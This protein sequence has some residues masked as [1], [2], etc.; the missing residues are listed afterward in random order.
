M[1]T[2]IPLWD[3]PSSQLDFVGVLDNANLKFVGSDAETTH[4]GARSFQ[5]GTAGNIWELLPCQGTVLFTNFFRASKSGSRTCDREKKTMKP[6]QGQIDVEL[7]PALENGMNLR[8]WQLLCNYAGHVASGYW[9]Q[10][11]NT[12]ASIQQKSHIN[13][14]LTLVLRGCK[15]NVAVL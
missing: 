5:R 13:G 4:L 14:T 7:W 11:S 6:S 12:V 8:I 2:T 3:L 1:K 10:L 15:E 9:V